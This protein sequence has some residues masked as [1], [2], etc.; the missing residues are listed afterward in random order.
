MANHRSNRYS[1]SLAL[2]LFVAS[3]ASA[4][5]FD[6][7]PTLYGEFR[8]SDVVALLRFDAASFSTTGDVSDATVVRVFQN[9]TTTPVAVGQRIS[10]HAD[11]G[12]SGYAERGEAAVFLHASPEGHLRA[13]VNVAYLPLEQL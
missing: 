12:L 4:T 9:R 5:V 11:A 13:E 1:L 2:I 7:P 3:R 6:R 8:V 10:F